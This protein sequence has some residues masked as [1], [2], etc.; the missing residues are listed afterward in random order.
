MR[1]GV[2]KEERDEHAHILVDTDTGYDAPKA[3][4]VTSPRSNR[5]RIRL[6]DPGNGNGMYNSLLVA[7]FPGPPSPAPV[8]QGWEG[9][10]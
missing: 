4:S 10:T 9:G 8:W 5:T 3:V 1:E 7:S 2:V 6:G